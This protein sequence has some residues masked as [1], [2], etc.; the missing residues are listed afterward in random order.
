MSHNSLGWLF[1]DTRRLEKAESAFRDALPLQKQAVADFP[2]RPE[3]RQELAQIHN[4]L[5]NVL[6]DTKRPKEAEAARAEALAIFKQLVAEFPNRPEFRQELADAEGQR[7]RSATGAR[8]LQEGGAEL[9]TTV[10]KN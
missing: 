8:G 4:N 9:E 2:N 5:G 3:F 6:R 10:K 1:Q 7:P